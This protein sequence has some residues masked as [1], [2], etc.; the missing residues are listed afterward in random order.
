VDIDVSEE[1]VA[2]LLRIEV[3]SALKMGAEC[4]FETSVSAYKSTQWHNAE[5][6]NLVI[7]AEKT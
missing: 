1:E 7:T 3:S 5:N 4:F 2:Y 6:H